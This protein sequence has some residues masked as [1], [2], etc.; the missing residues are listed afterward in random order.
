M[1]ALRNTVV[2]TTFD[3]SGT[4]GKIVC[5]CVWRVELVVRSYL[6]NTLTSEVTFCGDTP[7]H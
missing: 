5:A 7:E 2:S 3:F 6:W 1:L 4:L